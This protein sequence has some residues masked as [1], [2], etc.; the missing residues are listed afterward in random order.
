MADY[1]FDTYLWSPFDELPT[2]LGSFVFTGDTSAVGTAVITD[3]ET[4]VDGL[5]LDDNV[6]GSAETAT[7]TVTT[8]TATYTNIDVNADAGWTLYDPIDNVTF[9]VVLFNGKTGSTSFRYTLSEYPLVEGRTYEV[10]AF[11]N[12]PNAQ[13]AGDPVFTYADYVCYARGT[14][15]DTPDGPRAVETLQPGDQ[16]VTRDNGPQ[17]V[18]WTR[19][20]DHPLE[21]A[22]QEDRPVLIQSG[23]L[24]NGLPAE[25]LI[26]SSQHRLFVGGG[27][28]LERIFTDESLAPAKSLTDLPGI[29]FMMGKKQITWV[30]FACDRHEIVRANGCWSESL[31]LGPMALEVLPDDQRS[32]LRA[33]FGADA[34]ANDASAALNGPPARP[35]L[36]VTRT[37]R[38]VSTYL[39]SRR[40]GS[41]RNV[42]L[43]SAQ[44]N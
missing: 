23:A 12:Q 40:S 29:R 41:R 3:N 20:S 5:T 8:P 31:L 43:P 19:S 32:A 15:I 21:H 14:L 28:Q 44:A 27:S 17:P 39:D 42:C 22:G 34:A 35:C 1:T 25:N 16:V 38:I 13:V 10:L 24:G 4:G 7:A 6:A 18:R 2:A 26:V 30:H 37:R 9:Q 36:T 33:M 11:D